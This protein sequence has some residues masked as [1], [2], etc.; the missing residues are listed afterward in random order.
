MKEDNSILIEKLFERATEYGR[1]SYD[2]LKLRTL[3]KLTNIVSSNI[4]RL[5]IFFLMS[6]FLLFLNLGFSFWL[7]EIIGKIYYGFF[8]VGAFY[9]IIGIFIHFFMR[10]YFKRI[11]GNYIIK[12]VLK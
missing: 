4:P 8:I 9:G 10:K 3:D 2:L 7:G 5:V 1:T 12:Q 11:I 6:L